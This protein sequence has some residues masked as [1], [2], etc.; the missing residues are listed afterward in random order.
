MKFDAYFDTDCCSTSSLDSHIPLANPPPPYNLLLFHSTSLSH[1]I[2]APPTPAAPDWSPTAPIVDYSSANI[3]KPPN[4]CH[5]PQYDDT[6]YRSLRW[7]CWRGSSRWL[8][9]GG[10]HMMRMECSKMIIGVGLWAVTVM[11]SDVRCWGARMVFVGLEVGLGDYDWV[12][13]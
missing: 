11:M 1:S 4:S 6:R 5:H 10:G 2:T 9:G 7:W 8:V 3:S 12:D 13:C